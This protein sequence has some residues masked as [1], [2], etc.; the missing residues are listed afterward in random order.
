MRTATQPGIHD[1]ATD[2]PLPDQPRPVEPHPASLVTRVDRQWK[3][4]WRL[5]RASAG[6]H[7]LDPRPQDEG[8]PMGAVHRAEPP[9]QP[10]VPS[11]AVVVLPPAIGASTSVSPL[12]LRTHPKRLDHL[13]AECRK[14]PGD[15]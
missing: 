13:V 6:S 5:A 2:A 14:D 3:H 8:P 12:V 10:T 15:A 1:H 7:A 11:P 9:D 4:P